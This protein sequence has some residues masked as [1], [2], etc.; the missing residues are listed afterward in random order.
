[1]CAEYQDEAAEIFGQRLCERLDSGGDVVLDRSFYAREDRV[2]F[3]ELIE[4]RGGRV[5]LL[6]LRSDDKEKLW[7]RVENRRR[8]RH[9]LHGESL[10]DA[11]VVTTRETFDRY[12]DGFE[13]PDGEGEVVM[14]NSIE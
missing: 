4:R 2:H 11:A 14:T 7:A 9:T 10:G 5:V 12:W 1:M 8:Q 6:Y 13:G 3:K